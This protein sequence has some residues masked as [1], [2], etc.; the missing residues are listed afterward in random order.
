M[1]GTRTEQRAYPYP[2]VSV[3]K[4]VAVNHSTAHPHVDE[5]GTVY[6]MGNSWGGKGYNYNIICF[7]P[8]SFSLYLLG[9]FNFSKFVFFHVGRSQEW[10][11]GRFRWCLHRGVAAGSESISAVL[12]SQLRYDRPVFR[13]RRNVDDHGHPENGYHEFASSAVLQIDEV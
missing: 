9:L 4:M 2:K 8:G 7:P 10:R 5:D 6:N 13:L 12:L 3:G 1:T 11:I